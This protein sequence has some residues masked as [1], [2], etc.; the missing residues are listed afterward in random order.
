MCR[1]CQNISFL[2][3]EPQTTEGPEGVQRQWPDNISTKD[4]R[5]HEHHEIC[6]KTAIYSVFGA[7]RVTIG[8]MRPHIVNGSAHTLEP[9]ITQQ[10]RKQFQEFHKY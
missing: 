8:C 10:I 5:L 4:S 7:L 1:E 6:T 9:G 3:K 2:H